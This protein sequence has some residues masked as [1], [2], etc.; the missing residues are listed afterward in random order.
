LQNEQ[1]RRLEPRC[2][3]ADVHNTMLSQ[4]LS[5]SDQLR[6]E[7]LK[8]IE[9]LRHEIMDMQS[10]LPQRRTTP[11]APLTSRR[12][13][14]PHGR[15]SSGSKPQTARAK[16]LDSLGAT[17]RRH[18]SLKGGKPERTRPGHEQCAPVAR[19]A[20]VHASQCKANV[21]L[22]P[23]ALHACLERDNM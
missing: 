18:A 16:G 12:S 19:I 17:P 15:E 9:Q 11:G 3:E 6:M 5:R 20:L 2:Q 23:D 14:G 4:R 1:I 22:M 8:T 21:M 13:A 10:R 7:Q